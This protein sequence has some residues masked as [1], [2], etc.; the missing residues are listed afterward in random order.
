M[1]L[2]ARLV[3]VAMAVAV[4]TVIVF[5]ALLRQSSTPITPLPPSVHGTPTGD[6]EETGG[7]RRNTPGPST[8]PGV[9]ERNAK[10]V[11]MQSA[12]IVAR[13]PWAWIAGGIVHVACADPEARPSL[14]CNCA[15][16][17]GII[18]TGSGLPVPEEDLAAA[19]RDLTVNNN[20]EGPL[21]CARVCACECAQV[22]VVVCVYCIER[23]PEVQ[24]CPPPCLIIQ[25]NMAAS[26]G[27]T[28]PGPIRRASSPCVGSSIGNRAGFPAV[29]PL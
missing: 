2:H 5:S 14:M 22:C 26:F 29:S 12:G 23:G 17:S 1:R 28:R 15:A 16:A 13:E 18:A 6:A 24:R 3:V 11:A 27:G 19:A 10:R 8:P 25:H 21:R 4:G 9:E 20:Q 7:K